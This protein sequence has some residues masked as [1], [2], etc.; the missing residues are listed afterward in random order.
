MSV[1][2]NSL[3]I[4]PLL[5]AL[6]CGCG[7]KY[8]NAVVRQELLEW[9]DVQAPQPA[10]VD[11]VLTLDQAK[12]MALQDNPDLAAALARVHNARARLRQVQA[13]FFPQVEVSASAGHTHDVAQDRGFGLPQESYESYT[14]TLSASWLLFD[15]MSRNASR[16]AAYQA[17]LAGEHG[18]RDVAR[19][20]TEAVAQYWYLVVLAQ[21]RVD[22]AVADGKYNQT[23]LDDTRKMFE[24]GV[25][26][27]TDVLNFEVRVNAA[28]IRELD[29]RRDV[30]VGSAV[31]AALLGRTAL[32]RSVG[33][34]LPEPVDDQANAS[35]IIEAA[36]KTRPDVAVQIALFQQSKALLA[37]ARGDR[38]PKLSAFA[39]A[40]TFERDEVS[41]SSDDVDTSV[42]LVAEWDLFTGG[43]KSAAVDAAAADVDEAVSRMRGYWLDVV[44][45][46][47]QRA[48]DVG[49][50]AEKARV[51]TESTA[52][53]LRIRDEIQRQYNSGV[54][55]VTRLNEA[56][57]D[58]RVA[59][60]NLAVFK[61]EAALAR[62]RLA[63]AAGTNV[64][65]DG[66][67][68]EEEE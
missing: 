17:L 68:P 38:L 26:P 66:H 7:P 37:A 52:H 65:D 60:L 62:E 44:S 50:T 18:R 64:A 24:R 4:I 57:L 36:I 31:L 9:S 6:L 10:A 32:P 13:A 40:E 35:S 14:A 33:G 42:G 63:A 43:A 54:V 41:A 19:L 15:G 16:D 5:T 23:F 3:L 20:L 51:Q 29:A 39:T 25:R 1:Y 12:A 28:K 61:A 59:E 49:A 55:P 58:L 27:R 11:G 45:E 34:E 46:I 22:I 56:Q 47:R 8:D 2:S 48:A 67:E 21:R 30:E 53:T